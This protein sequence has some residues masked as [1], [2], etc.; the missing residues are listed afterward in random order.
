MIVAGERLSGNARWEKAPIDKNRLAANRHNRGR[1]RDI[2]PS[3]ERR[4]N[5]RIAQCRRQRLKPRRQLFSDR[6]AGDLVNGIKPDHRAVEGAIPRD[7]RRDPRAAARQY[8]LGKERRSIAPSQ[9]FDAIDQGTIMIDCRSVA[10]PCR[11]PPRNIRTANEMA[12]LA[13]EFSGN[14]GRANLASQCL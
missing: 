3:S 4:A 9:S 13:H 14:V 7:R 5:L 6:L 11:F 8:R 1:R 2:E 10:D 12:I